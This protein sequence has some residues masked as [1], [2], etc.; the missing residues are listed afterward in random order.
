MDIKIREKAIKITS[1]CNKC[2]EDSS[3][4][5]K[6]GRF[7]YLLILDGIKDDSIVVDKTWLGLFKTK[8]VSEKGWVQ[9]KCPNPKCEASK[10]FIYDDNKNDWNEVDV[11]K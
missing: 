11:K 3:F 6:P 8:R 2:Y 4:N 5:H 1:F 7:N 9:Y 10:K